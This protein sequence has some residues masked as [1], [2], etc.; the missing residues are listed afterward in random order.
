MKAKFT[1]ALLDKIE[2]DVKEIERQTPGM[3]KTIVS[4]M[5]L[6]NKSSAE[7]NEATYKKYEEASNAEAN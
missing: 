1:D 3:M 7:A 6:R 5:Y 4:E 2:R